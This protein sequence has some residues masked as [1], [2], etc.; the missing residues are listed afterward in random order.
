MCSLFCWVYAVYFGSRLCKL[1]QW[2]NWVSYIALSTSM[3]ASTVTVRRDLK[4]SHDR[5]LTWLKMLEEYNQDN[6]L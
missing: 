2:M 4:E 6:L 3:K 1:F 5:L